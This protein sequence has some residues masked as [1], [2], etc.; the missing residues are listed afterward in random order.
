MK[1]FLSTICLVAL[2]TGLHAQNRLN[3][4]FKEIPAFTTNVAALSDT[5]VIAYD[6]A[7]GVVAAASLEI[8]GDVTDGDIVITFYTATNFLA[9]GTAFVIG[10]GP[11]PDLICN[12]PGPGQQAVFVIPASAAAGGNTNIIAHF[13]WSNQMTN[14]LFVT[15]TLQGNRGVTPLGPCL[16]MNGITNANT[17]HFLGAPKVY[18]GYRSLP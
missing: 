9:A 15:D 12:T 4:Y 10:T 1:F 13:R 8:P 18:F 17:L 2:A 16:R 7:T 14:G 11:T 3:Y 6:N 5:N